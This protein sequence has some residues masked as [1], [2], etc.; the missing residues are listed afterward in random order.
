MHLRSRI[1]EI[2]MLSVNSIFLCLNHTVNLKKVRLQYAN[3]SICCTFTKHNVYEHSDGRRF[4]ELKFNKTIDKP[5]F[6]YYI[7]SILNEYIFNEWGV[8]H[9]KE[10][11]L[12]KGW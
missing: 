6:L 5:F 11:K 3:D 1:A 8:R 9:T 4:I 12:C 7:E 2:N 10:T